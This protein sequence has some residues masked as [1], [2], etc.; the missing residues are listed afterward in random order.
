MHCY[1]LGRRQYNM[2][3]TNITLLST[4]STYIIYTHMTI[5]LQLRRCFTYKTGKSFSTRV[6]VEISMK[7]TYR[8]PR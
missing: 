4:Y 8:V 2:N 6:P 1:K 7:K 3:A 5:S